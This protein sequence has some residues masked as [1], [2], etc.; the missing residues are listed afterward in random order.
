MKAQA[1]KPAAKKP[2][3]RIPAKKP[4]NWEQLAKRLQREL[5]NAHLDMEE[6]ER[7]IRILQSI[8]ENIEVNKSWFSRLL[9]SLKG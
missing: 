7:E 1:K 9:S 5:K 6:M 8:I 4:V 2:V 3:A